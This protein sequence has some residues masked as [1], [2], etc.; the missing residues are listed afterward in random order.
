MAIGS[1]WLGLWPEF[2]PPVVENIHDS[3]GHGVPYT[4]S[5][6]IAPP[7]PPPMHSVAMP[8]LVP[9]RF[10]ALTRCST[11][12]LPLQPTG[13]P[14]LMAPPS[15]LS[16][17]GSICPAAPSRPKISRQN[18]SSFQAARQPS[19]CVANASFNSQVSIS[20]SDN[21][22]RFNNS[23]ADNTGPSPM[24]LGSS[25]DHWLSTITA[26]G[27]SPCLATASSEA[28]IVHEAPSVICEELP[29][30]TWP[31]GRS[32][33]GFKTASFSGVESGRTPSS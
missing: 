29:A 27:F 19:T 31:Q 4:I 30:V 20:P 5:I 18:L 28:R 2:E 13:W 21:L 32:N 15:T 12:R 7:C 8:R 6:N 26:L 9:N 16:L 24:M 10:I 33:A 22:L 23:V 3:A 11:M 14:R 1:A 25:A 17:A